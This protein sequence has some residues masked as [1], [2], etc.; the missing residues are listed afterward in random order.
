LLQR[1]NRCRC[2]PAHKH[3]AVVD[4]QKCRHGGVTDWSVNVTAACGCTIEHRGKLYHAAA[5]TIVPFAQAAPLISARL[6]RS[7]RPYSVSSFLRLDITG[8]H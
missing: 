1:R 4:H 8:E 7:L 3:F 6:L 5:P 2:G